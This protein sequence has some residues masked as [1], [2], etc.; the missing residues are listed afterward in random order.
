M[1]R[2]EDQ[3]RQTLEARASDRT[4]DT[5]RLLSGT[6]SRYRRRRNRGL[7]ASV[8]VAVA[9]AAV[10][11]AGLMT[12]GDDK[13]AAPRSYPL[14]TNGYPAGPGGDAA[15]TTGRLTIRMTTQGVCAWIGGLEY[16]YLWPKGYRVTLHPAQLLDPTGKVIAKGGDMIHAGGG[17]DSRYPNRCAKPGQ[18]TFSISGYIGEGTN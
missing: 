17:G 16:A 15:K 12:F 7:V 3:L 14:P 18:Q 2:I 4:V 5:E 1:S 9:I 13:A 6:M 11:V 8:V 10:S